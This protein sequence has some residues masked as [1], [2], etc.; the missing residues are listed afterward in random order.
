MKKEIKINEWIE[1]YLSDN[2]PEE[3]VNDFLSR[4]KE[5]PLFTKEVDMHKRIHEIIEDGT[6]I[7][8]R[9]E[10]KSIHLKKI[11]FFNSIRRMSF[12]VTGGLIVGLVI[13][14][15]LKRQ[16]ESNEVTGKTQDNS[17][18]HESAGTIDEQAKII[19]S[20]SPLQN[21][22]SQL[23]HEKAVTG[24]SKNTRNIPEINQGIYENQSIV[25]NNQSNSD[26]PPDVKSINA[27]NSSD[28]QFR[29][30][31]THKAPAA[32]NII[33]TDCDKVKIEADIIELESCNNKPTGS[34]T[35]DDRTISGGRPP[36]TFSL[37]KDKYYDTLVFSALYPGNYSVFVKDGNDCTGI[38]GVALVGSTDCTYQAVFA[39][40]KGET[41]AVPADPNKEGMLQIFS[42]AGLL[43]FSS[44]IPEN[45]TILWNGETISGGQLPM[46]IY[47]FEIRYSDGNIFTGTVTIL[48]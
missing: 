15:V 47:M 19:P 2:L 16:N 7:H 42:K 8:I 30:D 23:Q 43:V 34:I 6:Y 10:L 38:I 20:P 27:D 17:I 44:R 1:A 36:Y 32:E 13:F 33:K 9:N 18:Q 24:E 40:L 25:I 21:S 11:N 45:E 35:I 22:K 26:A 39:P 31:Q 37:N 48:K 4:M 28:K 12:F 46:G 41:W 3:E 5:D 14:L 29:S